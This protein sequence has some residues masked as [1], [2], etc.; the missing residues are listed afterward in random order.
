MSKNLQEKWK[1]FIINSKELKYKLEIN[2]N[3]RMGTQKVGVCW[4][5]PP[6]NHWIGKKQ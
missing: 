5:Q 2:L 4:D 3:R 1:A 6:I